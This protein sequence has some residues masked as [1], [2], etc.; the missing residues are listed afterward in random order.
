MPATQ[1]VADEP[2]VRLTITAMEKPAWSIGDPVGSHAQLVSVAR[3]STPVL[4]EA[5]LTDDVRL[6]PADGASAFERNLHAGNLGRT[7]AVGV[8]ESVLV[9]G[10]ASRFQVVQI[11]PRTDAL[12]GQ[13][14]VAAGSFWSWVPARRTTFRRHSLSK[15][16]F[17]KAARHDNCS[18]R[19]RR[20]C[21]TRSSRER[22]RRC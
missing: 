17:Q 2:D 22:R 13:T 12:S 10:V 7:A 6:V 8:L 9:P 21:W 20:S 18:F 3:G 14:G 5:R 4:P 1:P 15:T 19:L 11:K 16:S